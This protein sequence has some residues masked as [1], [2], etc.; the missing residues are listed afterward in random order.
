MILISAYERLAQRTTL[1]YVYRS[2]TAK[3]ARGDPNTRR[4]NASTCGDR[5]PFLCVFRRTRVYYKSSERDPVKSE[6]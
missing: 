1:K 6:N 4:L 3:N 5:E 2:K